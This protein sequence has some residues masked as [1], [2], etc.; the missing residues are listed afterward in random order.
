MKLV[1]PDRSVKEFPEGTSAREIALAI[2]PG[3]EKAALAAEIDGRLVDLSYPVQRDSQ[4]KIITFADDIGKEIFWHSSAHI[5]ASAILRLFPE[6]KLAIGPAIPDDFSARFYYDIDLPR[7]LTESDLEAIEQ[8]M[9]KIAAEDS[10]FVRREMPKK[11]AIKFIKD[12]DPH[13]VYKLEMAEEFEEG[14]ISF[15]SHGNFLDMCRGPHIPS[16]GKLGAFKLLSIAGA[17]WRGDEKNKML[18]RIYGVSFPAKKMLDEHLKKLEM[19]KQRDHRTLGK[20]LDLFSITDEVGPGLVLWHPKGAL[21]RNLIENF[22]REAHLKNGYD[23]VYTPHIARQDLWQISGHLDFYKENMFGAMEIEGHKYQL[24]PMNCPFHIHIYKNKR[25]SYRDLP[26]R[27]AELGT[28]Y[29]FER[30]GVLHGLPRVRGF[31]QDDAHVFCRDDQ[32]EDELVR[33]LDFNLFF[34]ETFGFTDYETCLSTRPEKY[35]GTIENWDKATEAL[36]RALVIKNLDYKIDPGEGVFYGPK[37]DVKIKDILGRAWQCTT[38]QVDFNLPERFNLTYIGEDGGEHQ[39]VM[40]HRALLGSIER[41]F[42]VLI[43]HYGGYFP[44]WLAPVQVRILSVID[45][46]NPYIIELESLFKA[47][48]IRVETDLRN[49]KIGYKIREAENLKIPYMLIVGKKEAADGKVSVRK[50]RLG[51]Q[52]SFDP[53]DVIAEINLKIKDKTIDR[54]VF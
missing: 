45:E 12:N 28:V 50:H 1:F 52:G 16:T 42:G 19:A 13:D 9:A 40:V 26:F 17:Y 20:A 46:V 49:Q 54:E 44:V 33:L 18:Q 27:W 47:A 22:W 7:K 30:S 29:R 21:I 11:E 51:D 36:K 38:I 39:T 6:T 53:R 15:Y 48:D 41:F 2:G 4:I 37:I 8:E 34:L 14:A 32:L 5:M 31:T 43:E 10:R 23:I 25:R 35:V 24:K 3:L